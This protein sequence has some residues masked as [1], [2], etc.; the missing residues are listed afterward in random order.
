LFLILGIVALLSGVTMN[1]FNGMSGKIKLE[2]GEEKKLVMSGSNEADSTSEKYNLGLAI[3][4]E[5]L[6]L[7]PHDPDFEILLWKS[8]DTGAN[9]PSTPKANGFELI[10]Q[11]DPEPMKI[12]Q[13]EKSDWNFRMR[14]FYPNFEFAYEYPSVRDTIAP[15]A[16]GITIELK[17]VEGTPVVTLLSDPPGKHRLKDIVSLGASLEFFWQISSDSLEAIIAQHDSLENKIIFSG[18]DLKMYYLFN[19][20]LEEKSFREQEFYSM[21]GEDSTGFKVLF[22]FPDMAFLRAVPSTKG[23]ELLNPVAHL[24]I[25]KTGQGAI[26]AFVY[27]ETRSKKGGDFAIPGTDF[28]VGLGSKASSNVQYCDCRVLLRNEE[29]N[30]VDSLIF[31]SGERKSYKGLHFQPLECS[32]QYPKMVIMKVSKTFSLVPTIF[33]FLFLAIAL[34]LLFKGKRA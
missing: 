8:Q 32:D 28:K 4:L 11:F 26:D 13:I 3:S 16:P 17:T 7:R 19:G 33:G 15:E 23:N 10:D 34:L 6:T 5:D 12:R 21:P 29:S 27:P 2:E 18:S 1:Y 20:R 22:C 24:E 25:W 14:A 30:L 9:S 31:R